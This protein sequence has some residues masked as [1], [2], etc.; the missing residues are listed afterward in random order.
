MTLPVKRHRNEQVDELANNMIYFLT[1]LYELAGKFLLTHRIRQQATKENGQATR[2]AACR[3]APTALRR[4]SYTSA[5][6]TAGEGRTSAVIRYLLIARE[7]AKQLDQQP[8]GR[9]NG[10]Y[11]FK[12]QKMG[13]D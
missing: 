4:G 8:K 13:I 3:G 2:E 11:S 5:A 6:A 7:L 9:K 12:D 10:L 1:R